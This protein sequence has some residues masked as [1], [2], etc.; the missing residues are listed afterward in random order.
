MYQ[1]KQ[2]AINKIQF[3]IWTESGYKHEA[4]WG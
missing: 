2:K 4:I 3:E 1:L